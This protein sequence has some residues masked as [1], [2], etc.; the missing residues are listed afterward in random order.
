MIFDFFDDGS[1]LIDF[2]VGVD[3]GDEHAV[4]SVGGLSCAGFDGNRGP[5]A[6]VVFRIFQSFS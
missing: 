6:L 2:E 5:E 1:G 3:G 4:L